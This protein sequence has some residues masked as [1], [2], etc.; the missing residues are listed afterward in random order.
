MSKI[1]GIVRKMD[2][3]GRISIPSEYRNVL[4]LKS[5]D[6]L[7]IKLDGNKMILKKVQRR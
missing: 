6:W 1:T 7:E 3:M 5:N 2:G 4:K